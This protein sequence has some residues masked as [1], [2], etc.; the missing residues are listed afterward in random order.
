MKNTASPKIGIAR[1]TTSLLVAATVA[2]VIASQ[3]LGSNPAI[4]A[5]NSTFSTGLARALGIAQQYAGQFARYSDGTHDR[6]DV[7]NRRIAPPSDSTALTSELLS[8]VA[9]TKSYSEAILLLRVAGQ[10]LNR[11]PPPVPSQLSTKPNDPSWEFVGRNVD[12]PYAVQQ[13]LA[14]KRSDRD[15]AL[16][17]LN[18]RTFAE[19][20][21][22][23]RA[24]HLERRREMALA[25]GWRF[26]PRK[27]LYV[28]VMNNGDIWRRKMPSG[29]VTSDVNEEPGSMRSPPGE[30]PDELRSTLPDNVL[31]SV[32]GADTRELRSE[33]NGFDMQSI[34]W[35]PKGA[36]VD[37][38]RT[39][40]EVPVEVDCSATK[41]RE[42]LLATA[43][44][45]Q[46]KDGA[47]NDN[48]RWIPGADGIDA[49]LN[50]TDPSPNGFKSSF[51][52][53]VR[54]NWFDH[55]WANYD[56]GLFVLHDNASSCSL[57]WHGWR[58]RS[59]LLND[60]VHLYG[61][62]G[63]TRDCAASPLGSNNC[64]GS[65]YG[66]S[67]TITY[68]GAYRVR[69]RIDTQPGQSG[70]GVYE[71]DNGDRYV[72]A[73]HRGPVT[74]DRNDAVRI[75]DGNRDMINDAKAD[76]PPNACD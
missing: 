33:F 14:A 5:T 57:P 1:N 67:G 76:Y 29:Y 43:G 69:Y 6:D 58:K 39:T 27:D 12:L 11:L 4:A 68:A 47:W 62:P 44:H 37:E 61:Y 16:D 71:I 45:C 50:G 30:E 15:S 72:L 21:A 20:E 49:E 31:F 32:F 36:I 63:E 26:D 73:T 9:N 34:V 25:L 46:F 65:I 2:L 40:Q 75:N 24:L 66:D 59:G 74:D 3:I 55:E 7:E 41:I 54:G 56:F 8:L 22:R 10:D 17:L 13:A 60:T 51:A 53:V 64:H 28:A 38:D 23:E 18:D 52:R 48:R 35:E 42:R 19:V 70:A